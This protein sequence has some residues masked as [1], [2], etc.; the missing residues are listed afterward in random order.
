LRKSL[1]GLARNYDALVLDNEA[2]MEHLSRRTTNNIDVLIAV[3]DPT[4]PAL[5][6]AKRIVTLSRELPVKVARR[7]VLVNRVG[8][9]GVPAGIAKEIEG[10]SVERLPDVPQDDEVQRAGAEGRDVFGVGAETPALAA[11]RKVAEA[12]KPK[13][14]A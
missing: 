3:M 9:D 4:V 2:G 11:A 13:V 1:D 14:E 6:A 5:R 10:L 8:P 7:A 12:L